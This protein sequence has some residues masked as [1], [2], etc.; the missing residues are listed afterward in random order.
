MTTEPVLYEQHD[1]VVVLTLNRRETRNAL[2]TSMVDAIVEACARINTDPGVSCV[3]L[4]SCGPAFCAGGNVKEM[5]AQSGMFAGTPAEMR[6]AY[7][8][9][10]HRLPRAIHALE[11]PVIA[12]VDGPAIGAG[13]DLA[14]MCDS[15]LASDRAVFAESFIR[16]GL[17]S[18]DGGAWLLPR[19]IGGS[20]AFEMTLTGDSI[21]AAQ[22]L[23]WGLVS[24]V[25]SPEDVFEKALAL[26]SRIARHPPH[27]IKLNKRLLREAEHVDLDRSLDIAASLQAIAQSTDD[28]REA[29]SAFVERR[30]PRFNGR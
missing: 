11:V 7:R 5:Q 16:L 28:Y 9:G 26:A 14:L 19:L 30:E 3:V 12:V 13:L 18:G 29:V 8:G 4:R 22:A 25:H 15:R 2:D 10:I 24:A 1:R 20:R 27:S 17:V 23:A 21:G 6:I